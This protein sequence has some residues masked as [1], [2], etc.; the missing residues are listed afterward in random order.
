MEDNIQIIES[1]LGQAIQYGKTSIELIKLQAV[2]KTSD[3][4]SSFVPS[5]VIV[6]TLGCILFFIN[7]GAAFWLG[8]V[9][10]KIY[11]GFFAVAGF[12]ALGFVK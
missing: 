6:I 11:F 5:S 9:L 12:Y 3:S 8:E 1:L 7:V 10:G 2:D 4:V